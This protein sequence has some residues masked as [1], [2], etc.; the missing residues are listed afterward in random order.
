MD[1]VVLSMADTDARTWAYGELSGGSSSSYSSSVSSSVTASS[2]L[3]DGVDASPLLLLDSP[4]PVASDIGKPTA[5]NLS[6]SP[7]SSTISSPSSE[8]VR[9]DGLL[10]PHGLPELDG[11]PEELHGLPELDGLPEE[12]QGLPELDGLRLPIC[13]GISGLETT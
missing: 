6:S 13:E 1:N 11:L 5:L 9:V 10:E 3:S 7:I 12:L 2:R 8:P 4:Y